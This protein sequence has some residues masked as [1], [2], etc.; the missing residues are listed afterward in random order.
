MFFRDLKSLEPALFPKGPG[1]IATLHCDNKLMGDRVVVTLWKYC[2]A[3]KKNMNSAKHFI[4]E[5]YF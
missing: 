4:S 5:N 2:F 1:L 3:I